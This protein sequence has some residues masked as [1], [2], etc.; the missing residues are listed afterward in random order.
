MLKAALFDFD[1]TLLATRDERIPIL[2]ST[3]RDF[4]FIVDNEKLEKSWG[5]PFNKLI[6]SIA[7]AIDYNIFITKYAKNME[8]IPPKILPGALEV[9][10]NL[11]LKNIAV[12]VVSSSSNKLMIQDLKRS[13]ILKYIDR[14]WGYE[15][16]RFHKPDKRTILGFLEEL[17]IKSIGRNEVFYMSDGISDFKIAKKNNLPF[18]AVLTGKNR[19]EDFLAAGLEESRIFSSM[20]EFYIRELQLLLNH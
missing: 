4:G 18:Y 6:R 11:A 14:C 10:S 9:I 20:Q 1:D 12:Y 13:A 7:P 2:K 16:T 19:G 8:A 15:D 5:K 17:E 3:I